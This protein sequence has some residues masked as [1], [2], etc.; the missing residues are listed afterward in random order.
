[1]IHDHAKSVFFYRHIG[2]ITDYE[3]PGKPLVVGMIICDCLL[4]KVSSQVSD[5]RVGGSFAEHCTI[6]FTHLIALN[7]T[8]GRPGC[9]PKPGCPAAQRGVMVIFAVRS[10]VKNSNA[11][12]MILSPAYDILYASRGGDMEKGEFLMNE[13][14][15]KELQEAYEGL[16]KPQKAYVILIALSTLIR[17]RIRQIPI[18]WVLRQ[19]KQDLKRR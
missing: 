10:L 5:N 19:I 16:S 4:E 17:H 13:D 8:P 2:A 9:L 7:Y 15:R 14:R 1:V 6:P 12:A 3:L 18:N 11:G